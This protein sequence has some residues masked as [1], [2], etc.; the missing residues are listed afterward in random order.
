ME[1][2][3]LIQKLNEDIEK[4]GKDTTIYYVMESGLEQDEVGTACLYHYFF[5]DEKPDERTLNKMLKALKKTTLGSFRSGNL[6]SMRLLQM[7]GA[8]LE[9]DFKDCINA[10]VYELYEDTYAKYL[11]DRVKDYDKYSSK[12]WEIKEKYVV[13]PDDYISH[14]KTL[15]SDGGR[16]VSL[17]EC[18]QQD[19]AIYSE[20]YKITIH[21]QEEDGKAV[22]DDW[23]LSDQGTVDLNDYPDDEFCRES[24]LGELSAILKKQEKGELEPFV[25]DY[26]RSAKILEFR[27]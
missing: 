3:A 8:Q 9:I 23:L 4:Y 18:C 5:E 21:V 6:I 26:G 7:S 25:K 13:N 27:R 22:V 10:D 24:T 14:L 12:Y 11:K 2:R 19:L 1:T 20:A 17:M 15:A 16:K